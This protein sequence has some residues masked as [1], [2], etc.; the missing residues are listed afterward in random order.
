[1][2]SA[3]LRSRLAKRAVKGARGR[4][5]GRVRVC[6]RREVMHVRM[7]VRVMV[8]GEARRA[9]C[10]ARARVPRVSPARTRLG[11][12]QRGARPPVP[13]LLH[14]RGASRGAAARAAPRARHCMATRLVP[15]PLLP[16][17]ALPRRHRATGAAATSA[18]PH[19]SHLTPL[20]RHP[21]I[22]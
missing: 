17:P 13:A 4:V 5:N 18:L 10:V 22:R 8:V 7:V 16:S 2:R 9:R 11:Q 1:M 12:G 19:P 6:V 21:S 20:H 14:L 15:A 3:V